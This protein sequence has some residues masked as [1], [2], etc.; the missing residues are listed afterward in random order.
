MFKKKKSGNLLFIATYC[1]TQNYGNKS[2]MA[3]FK[4]LLCTQ[5]PFYC[6]M[7]T[8]SNSGADK[9][10]WIFY[11]KAS[12]AP[13]KMGKLRGRQNS[14]S[15][16]FT[17]IMNSVSYLPYAFH[18]DIVNIKSNRYYWAGNALLSAPGSLIPYNHSRAQ[19]L[20]YNAQISN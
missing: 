18:L 4:A 10:C 8:T 7:E 14:E 9:T 16:G 15:R 12:N 17:G 6:P 3:N 11:Q 2:V 13:R 19:R 1:M 5:L 20:L